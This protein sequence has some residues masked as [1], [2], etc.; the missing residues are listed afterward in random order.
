M[1][2]ADEIRAPW[3]CAQV[4][5]LNA[6]QRR[7]GMHPFTCGADHC[8]AVL[9]ARRDGWE[10]STHGY[11]QDWAHAFM[12]DPSAWPNSPFGVRRTLHG[13]QATKVADLER[14]LAALRAV[15]RGYCPACGRGDAAPTVAD[16]E[17]ER[18][19]AAFW[20]DQH[21]RA[22]Q[23][24]SDQRQRAKNAEAAVARVHHYADR[25][26]ATAG[27]EFDPLLAQI[28]A[29][30]RAALDQPAPTTA[31]QA[32]AWTPPP[33]GDRR[34][35]LPDSILAAIDVPPY[36]STACQAADQ[37]SVAIPERLEV[38]DELGQW[39]DRLHARCRINNK[40]TGQLCACGCHQAQPA[41]TAPRAATLDDILL[42]RCPHCPERVPRSR[43]DEH[44]TTAHAELPPCTATFDTGH[45]LALCAYRVG[46]RD[47]EY[48]D[49][50]ATARDEMG[51]TVWNDA[52]HGATPHRA[53]EQR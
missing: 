45:D 33:P 52:A 41:P 14:Q 30:I 1:T 27:N 2:P 5:A 28:A 26:E 8:D 6:F 20:L 24:A 19:N 11:V 38:S 35:Q 10:C 13:E 12:A 53:E 50:H 32:S 39:A 4:T 34:E 3:T 37:C 23:S 18:Q 17:T 25:L 48:G 7:G 43:L 40:F 9:T 44:V 42:D 46:H 16:W 47:G 22:R 36:T 51:R 29:G 21:K 15:A 49:W 31:A